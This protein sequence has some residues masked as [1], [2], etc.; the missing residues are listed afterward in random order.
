MNW[1]F[2]LIFLT[3]SAF[4]V[5]GEYISGHDLA[6]TCKLTFFVKKGDKVLT[7]TCT[8]SFIG[9]K[10]FVTA[11]HCVDD[12][13]VE[14]P[15]KPFF[16]CPGSDKKYSIKNSFPMKNARPSEWQDLAM[17]KVEETVDAEPIQLP[18]SSDEIEKALL[19]K[20]NC[21]MSGYGLDNEEKYGVLKTA[22]VA[23]L[24]NNPKDLFSV[25]SSQRV[26]LRENYTDHGDSGGPLY[27]KTPTGTILIGAV[28]GGVKGVKFN[29]VEKINNALEWIN[30]HRDNANSNEDT[31]KRVMINKDLCQNL[32]ECSE[33]MKKINMLSADVEKVMSE[34]IKKN[35]DYKM[36]IIV[37]G[38]KSLVKME[39]VWEEMIKQW[40]KYDCYKKLYP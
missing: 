21:Y 27:C 32:L 2:T 3:T 9:N 1:F 15:Q 40:E 37:G 22:R 20:D 11:E 16:T 38:E 39:E 10:T 6:S 28:H 25:G 24:E 30:Y 18:T 7:G 26:R 36:E 29:D 35:D 5:K 23:S 4:A 17:M 33:A 31:F 13:A 19:D 12:V 34:L 14:A 8:G